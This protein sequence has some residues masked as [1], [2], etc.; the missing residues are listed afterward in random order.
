MVLPILC[1]AKNGNPN[2]SVETEAFCK[3]KAV[4]WAFIC[5]KEIPLWKRKVS[6]R[7]PSSSGSTIVDDGRG[8]DLWQGSHIHGFGPSSGGQREEAVGWLAF[9]EES[10]SQGEP[11]VE[12]R[13][14]SF[15]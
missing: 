7:K 2:W 6:A 5:V 10:D 14:D 12:V 4:S 11:S 13:K 3:E 8:L 1:A 15:V 9:R